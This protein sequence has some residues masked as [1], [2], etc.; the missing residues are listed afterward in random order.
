MSQLT[1]FF[2][3]IKQA[4]SDLLSKL[5]S[6]PAY[7]RTLEKFDELDPK[8]QHWISA[9][10]R[11]IVIT[12]F[13]YFF[14]SPLFSLWQSKSTLSDQHTL[15]S[16][17]K[18]FNEKLATQPRPAPQPRD[19]QSLPADTSDSAMASVKGFIESIGIP[20][21]SYNMLSS[22]NGHLQVEV[23][24][25]NLRQAQALIYQ[26][27]GWHPKVVSQILT[28]KVHP[29]D[30]QKLQLAM[31]LRHESGSPFS[32][33]TSKSSTSSYT[34]PPPREKDTSYTHSSEPRN[35]VNPDD[36]YEEAIKEQEDNVAVE[37]K[38]ATTDSFDKELEDALTEDIGEN[39]IN[40]LPPPPLDDDEDF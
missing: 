28:V 29:D 10:S 6:S 26:V 7:E 24:Q 20:S 40:S 3:K 37:I 22:S 39:D 27:D 18:S 12:F 15:L 13:I 31:T 34:A 8:Q 30:K 16:E 11:L 36:E 21:G 5:E 19:W 2:E 14:C 33:S 32:A 9:G 17:M 4:L 38:G 23:P 35:L 1:D 25:I